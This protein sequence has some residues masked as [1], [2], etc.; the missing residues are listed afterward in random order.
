MLSFKSLKRNHNLLKTIFELKGDILIA[1]ADC[2]FYVPQDYIKYRMLTIG[3]K[4][5]MLAVA[6][7]VSNGEYGIFNGCCKITIQPDV[8]KN[9]LVD[10]KEYIEFTFTKGNVIVPR[11]VTVKDS[12]LVYDMFKYF[13]TQGKIP[14]F[15]SVDDLGNIFTYHK[16]YGGINISPNNV[17]F[18]I[19][20]SM[21]CRDSKDTFKYYRHSDQKN[22]PLIIPFNSVLFNARSTTAKLLGANLEDGFTN[23]LVNP[24]DEPDRL[25]TLLRL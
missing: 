9:V 1:K 11:T 24:S 4:T 8:V 22:E 25:E 19:V 10:G 2:K 13:Y 7:V 14:G 5:E 18:E 3:E 15:L 12:D 20:A 16:E 23:A 17:P 21:I 6:A